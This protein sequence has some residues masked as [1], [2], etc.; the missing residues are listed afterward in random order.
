M[1]R[2]APRLDDQTLADLQG[3]LTTGYGHLPQAAYVFVHI[4]R[5]ETARAWLNREMSAND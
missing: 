5:A 2:S 4:E 3:I 1:T